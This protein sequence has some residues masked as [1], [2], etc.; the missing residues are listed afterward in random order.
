MRQYEN[1]ERTSENRCAPRSYYIPGGVSEYQLLNG[2]WNFAYFETPMDLPED[3]SYED[4]LVNYQLIKFG[5]GDNDI[6]LVNLNTG[7][8]W[9][10]EFKGLSLSFKNTRFSYIPMKDTEW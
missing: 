2:T 5:T 7:I 8:M 1:P 10:V 6:V 9:K 3:L 4:Q